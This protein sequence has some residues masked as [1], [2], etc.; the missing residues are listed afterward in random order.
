MLF[1]C[2]MMFKLSTLTELKDLQAL[3]SDEQNRDFT[4]PTR[5]LTVG[6]IMCLFGTLAI[7]VLILAAQLAVAHGVDQ[8]RAALLVLNRQLGVGAVERV[9]HVQPAV[10]RRQRGEPLAE[11]RELRLGR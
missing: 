6:M 10:A 1:T 2:C 3:M 4:I 7:G 8:R 5:L 11:G 9:E